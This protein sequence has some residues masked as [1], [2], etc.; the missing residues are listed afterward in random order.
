MHEIINKSEGRKDYGINLL[1]A[2]NLKKF[3]EHLIEKKR[4]EEELSKMIENENTEISS[5]SEVKCMTY[6]NLVV[7][8]KCLILKKD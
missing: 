6:S 7:L 1:T 3:E 4:N 2:Y 8:H 5:T